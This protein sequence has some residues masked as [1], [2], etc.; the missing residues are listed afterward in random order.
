MRTQLDI[1]GGRDGAISFTVARRPSPAP[2]ND[3][4]LPLPTLPPAAVDRFR[5]RPDLQ[6][7]VVRITRRAGRTAPG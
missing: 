7:P 5:S 4:T 2:G 6:A 3:G 1:A